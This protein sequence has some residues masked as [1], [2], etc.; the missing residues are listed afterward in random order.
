MSASKT[1]FYEQ[2]YESA[3]F[4][5]V[6]SHRQQ[7]TNSHNIVNSAGWHDARNGNIGQIVQLLPMAMAFLKINT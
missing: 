2:Q 1:D 4:K 7:G 3:S 6:M 5:K